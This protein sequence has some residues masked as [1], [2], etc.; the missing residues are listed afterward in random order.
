MAKM[1]PMSRIVVAAIV[2]W[3]ALAITP[4]AAREDEAAALQAKVEELSRQGKYADAIPLAQR[5]L[6]IREKTLGPDHPDVA[7]SLNN[8]ATATLTPCPWR[9]G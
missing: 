7:T 1:D 3:T 2:L 4:A 5:A 6:A 9:S 8:L